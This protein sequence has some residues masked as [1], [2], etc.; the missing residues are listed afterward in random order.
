MEEF[1]NSLKSVNWWV[2][3]IAAGILVN[4]FSAYL[5]PFLDKNINSFLEKQ[6]TKKRIK[7]EKRNQQFEK[8]VQELLDNPE[9]VIRI[10]IKY[11]HIYSLA[12]IHMV[13]LVVLLGISRPSD[14]TSWFSA[15]IL[16][17]FGYFTY[18]ANRFKIR[19][20]LREYDKR[21]KDLTPQT[22]SNTG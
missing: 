2:S 19:D 16:L 4:I 17:I 13:A 21:K 22:K 1:L 7:S 11:N 6:S 20:I 14:N 9:M 3:V 10:E 8:K 12:N 15:F 18:S 5:K